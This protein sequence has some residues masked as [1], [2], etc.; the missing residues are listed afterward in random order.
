MVIIDYRCYFYS[1]NFHL[2]T[3]PIHAE[4]LGENLPHSLDLGTRNTVVNTRDGVS[5]CLH[6]VL[7]ELENMVGV[8]Q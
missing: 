7:Q 8:E 4:T 1:Q 3:F 6:R 2:K 5:P